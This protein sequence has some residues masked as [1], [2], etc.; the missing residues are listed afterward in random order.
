MLYKIAEGKPSVF[1][2][3]QPKCVRHLQSFCSVLPTVTDLYF[4][5][6]LRRLRT[7]WKSRFSWRKQKRSW[8][9]RQR[10]ASICWS[11]TGV[12]NSGFV[13]SHLSNALK[14]VQPLRRCHLLVKEH[15]GRAVPTQFDQ[16]SCTR[17]PVICEIGGNSHCSS[18]LIFAISGSSGRDWSG[19]KNMN[20]HAGKISLSYILP[21]NG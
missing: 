4:C 12:R 20:L 5:V 21:L 18:Q 10:A 6:K 17:C 19:V 11:G 1:Y 7:D 14:V 8:T 2:F 15:W 3:M 16:P 9:A 13:T